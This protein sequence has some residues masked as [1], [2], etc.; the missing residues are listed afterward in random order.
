MHRNKRLRDNAREHQE[1]HLRE[2]EALKIGPPSKILNYSPTPSPIKRS[3]INQSHQRPKIT[4]PKPNKKEAVVSNPIRD[5][6]SRAT[7]SLSPTPNMQG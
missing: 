2:V 3:I 1:R 7:A 6:N 4:C 5:P